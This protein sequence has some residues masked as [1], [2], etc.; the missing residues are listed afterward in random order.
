ME[1]SPVG[2]KGSNGIARRAVQSVGG[3]RK[4]ALEDRI[5]AEIDAEANVVTLTANCAVAC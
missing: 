1:E 3:V 5:G 2:R 4:P